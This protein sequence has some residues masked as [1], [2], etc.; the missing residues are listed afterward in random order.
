MTLHR[1]TYDVNALATLL[2][3]LLKAQSRIDRTDEDT[4][5]TEI[6][7]RVIGRVERSCG[8]C[9]APQEYEWT[10]RAGTG[11]NYSER[12]PPN[13]WREMAIPVRGFS[14]VTAVD[15]GGLPVTV[16][17]RGD[18]DQLRFGPVWVGRDPSGVQPADVFTIK[19]GY[20]AV[21]DIP[22]ELRDTLVRY[23][24]SLWEYREAWGTNVDVMPEWVTEALGIFWVPEV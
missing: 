20:D 5:A 7:A 23:G 22:P 3:P 13:Y 6:M 9:I 16:T 14:E 19:A 4:Q 10:P 8:I 1:I 2:L 21:A 18:V 12:M 11:Y 24:A 15:S 17:L